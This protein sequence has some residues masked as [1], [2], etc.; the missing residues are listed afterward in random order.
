MTVSE[1]TLLPDPDSPTIPSVSPGWIDVRDAVDRL[2]DAVVG[3]E[4]DLAGP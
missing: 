4:V 3:L 2:D 1:L